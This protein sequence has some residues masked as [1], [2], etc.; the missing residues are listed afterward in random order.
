[1]G[2]PGGL[3]ASP[4]GYALLARR[5]HWWTAALL[6]VQI[7]VGLFMVRYGGA[8]NF[9]E[10]SGELYDGHKLLGLTLLLL[11]AVRLGYRLAHGAPPSEPSLA[12]WQRVTSQCTH[13]AIYAMLLLV[14]CIGWLAI[15]YYGPFRPFGFPLPTLVAE[16]GER[17][18]SFFALHKFAAYALMALIG[19]HI[20]AALWHYLILKDGVM[21]RMLVRAGI[22]ER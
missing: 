16:N 19:M 13:W 4:P 20:A 14:P 5:L 2:T 8:T 22:R 21:R 17:A 12:R 15:S 3:P 6:A 1:M 18:K 10:P 11:A 9:A 7:P